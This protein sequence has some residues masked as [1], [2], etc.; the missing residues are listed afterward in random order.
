M[1]F[2]DYLTPVSQI[3]VVPGQCPTDYIDWFYLISHPFMRL[4]HPGDPLR[5]PPIVQDETYVELDMPQYP[6]A[7][8]TMEE[9]PVHAPSDVEQPRHT[10]AI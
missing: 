3:C 2:F 5:Y 4:T 8:A 6:V 10:V 1:H 7:V 9:A